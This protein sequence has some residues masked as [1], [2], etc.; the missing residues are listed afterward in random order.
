MT[1]EI[2]KT[3]LP[4]EK[5]IET[6]KSFLLDQE[7]LG[8]TETI[9]E[10]SYYLLEVYYKLKNYSSVISLAKE[11]LDRRYENSQI[12]LKTANLA[13]EAMFV[14]NDLT[15]FNRFFSIKEEFIK[16]IDSDQLVFDQL[17]YHLLCANYTEFINLTEEYLLISAD[18]NKRNFCYL[19]LTRY[20]LMEKNYEKA[21]NFNQKLLSSLP[22]RTNIPEALVHELEILHIYKDEGT[23]DL[24]GNLLQERKIFSEEQLQRI[25][26]I[27]LTLMAEEKNEHKLF[28]LQTEYEDLFEKLPEDKRKIYYEI[29]LQAYWKTGGFA[30]TIFQEKLRAL[31]TKKDL[32]PEVIKPIVNLEINP[33]TLPKEKTKAKTESKSLYHALLRLQAHS[34]L[35]STDEKYREYLRHMGI[36]LN[37]YHEIDEF[38]LSFP[39]EDGAYDRLFYNFKAGRLYES[40][41]AS[42]VI[43]NTFFKALSNLKEPLVID[44]DRYLDI[45]CPVSSK[46]Y[47]AKN[48]NNIIV[49]PLLSKNKGNAMLVAEVRKLEFEFIDDI[50][51]ILT[52]FVNLSRK[53]LELSQL[54]KDAVLKTEN[55]QR[56]F[57]E[58]DIP[59]KIEVDG[60][61]ILNP[62]ATI[63]FGDDVRNIDGL[64]K[65]LDNNDL[66][67]YKEKYQAII[68]GSL[69]TFKVDFRIRNKK[70]YY[71]EM[72]R[73]NKDVLISYFVDQT[74]DVLKA[75]TEN[76]LITY[77][78][79]YNV[80]NDYSLV[81]RITEQK[82]EKFSLILIE[83]YRFNEIAPFFTYDQKNQLNKELIQIYEH[84]GTVYYHAE[85]QFIIYLELNDSR[86]V[87]RI[88][89]EL[90]NN[91]ENFFALNY[92]PFSLS[93][94]IAYL[95]YPVTIS[96]AD[97]NKIL[98]VLDITLSKA[99]KLKFKGV[100]SIVEFQKPDFLKDRHEEALISAVIEGFKNRQYSVKYYPVY[101]PENGKLSGYLPKLEFANISF[102][103]EYIYKT[104]AERKLVYDLDLFSFS[105]VMT[106]CYKIMKINNK[107][108]R[109]FIRAAEESIANPQFIKELA[110]LCK[111]HP[112]LA[113]SITIIISEYNDPFLDYSES[114]KSLKLL[115]FKIFG[116]NPKD[117]FQDK[118]DGIFLKPEY[119]SYY[120]AI[121]DFSYG[122]TLEFITEKVEENILKDSKY[123][124]LF[125]VNRKG[126]VDLEKYYLEDDPHG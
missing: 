32:K 56:L 7:L 90:N 46:F 122:R 95:R 35:F 41:K 44:L 43:E 106:Q 85:N 57:L 50:G 47:A 60:L 105:I 51:K 116:N 55:Y 104:F 69:L 28:V 83:V 79:K 96:E 5:T 19:E 117:L 36:F 115:G 123:K 99:Q 40:R 26:F 25:L 65:I 16:L 70:N 61:F 86:S 17:R 29:C 98:G 124:G 118:T 112:N 109:I 23:Y 94:N 102:N 97:P 18:N 100:S 58:I 77:N 75:Q 74:K 111:N 73:K 68:N 67:N 88:I 14:S 108:V 103:S 114:I 113:S 24:S 27:R 66:N 126:F 119:L 71:Y 30:K 63:L 80:L 3:L 1:I 8:N 121:R 20:Y 92:N 62:A 93:L 45:R 6:I 125:L 72:A 81:K 89:K 84:H 33:Q 21:K 9:G 12:K 120:P 39:E 54:V 76:T 22:Y 64:F 10:A 49:I 2:I 31:E 91:A 34:N 11:I 107:T 37:E 78:Q 101:L 48:T 4:E 59:M 15:N 87:K 52:E 42:K 82:N 13:I 53:R 38:V 110:L